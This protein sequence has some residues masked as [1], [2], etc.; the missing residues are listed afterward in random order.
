MQEIYILFVTLPF[1]IKQFEKRRKRG[2]DYEMNFGDRFLNWEELRIIIERSSS[3]RIARKSRLTLLYDST[4]SPGTFA[5]YFTPYS[6]P[7]SFFLYIFFAFVNSTIA[8]N[9]N[10]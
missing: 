6:I 3:S 10:S 2:Y 4:D 7:F 5:I 1:F 9:C 8:C